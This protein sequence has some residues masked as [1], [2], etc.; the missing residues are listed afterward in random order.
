MADQPESPPTETPPASRSSRAT[1]VAQEPAREPSPEE[2]RQAFDA[3][4]QQE[5]DAAERK[6]RH[7]PM[8]GANSQSG[9]GPTPMTYAVG[10]LKIFQRYGA[11]YEQ[12]GTADGGVLAIRLDA[13]EPAIVYHLRAPDSYEDAP[14]S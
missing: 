1:P 13:S 9:A 5:R 8:M 4:M 11:F 3:R 12:V 7:A 10:G 14:E 2:V 6:I